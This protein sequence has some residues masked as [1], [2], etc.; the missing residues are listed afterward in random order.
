MEVLKEG[1]GP[2]FMSPDPFAFREQ[3]RAK[4]RGQRPKIMS[5]AEAVSRYVRDGAYLA[6]GGFGTNRIPVALLHEI[7]RQRRKDLGFAGHSTTHDYQILVAGGGLDRVDAAYIIGLEARGLSPAA[8][9][10]HQEGNIRLCEWSNAS[11]GW[12][13][14]AGARGIPFMATY[15]TAGTDTFEHSAAKLVK[16]P[17]TGKP[18]VLVPALNPDVGLLHVHK[19]D[20]LGNCQIQGITVADAEVAAA[21]RVTLVT[22]EQL[23][24]T[25]YFR[26][27]P[28]RTTIPWIHVDAVIEVPCG[29]YPGNMPG[30][31][32]SDERHLGE[33]LEA[34]KDPEAFR[35]FLDHYIYSSRTFEE[36]LEKCGGRRRIEELRDAEL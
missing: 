11:L 22:C 2:L 19:A 31:Y 25:D 5:V 36:Y 28:Q 1:R 35:N 27:D 4:N 9:R 8:R 18:V 3:R 33:W 29:S 13:L 12:R 15:V 14:S 30:L 23:V 7:V 26:D 21:S 34:E 6:T 20:A 17:F 10:A 16:C 24:P 32:Y